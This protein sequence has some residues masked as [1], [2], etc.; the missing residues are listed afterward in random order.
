VAG[1][2]TVAQDNEEAQEAWN[3]VLFDRFV[4]FRHIMV[5]GLA[6][7]GEEALRRHPPRPGDRVL[8][9]GCGFGDTAQRLA[10][11][12]GPEGD[13][14]GTDVAPRFIETAIEDAREAGVGNVRFAVGDL[15]VT[16]FEETFDYTFSRFGT[17]FFA[18]PGAAMRN[19][20]RAL[21]PGGRLCLVVW[22]RKL[23]NPWMHRAEEVVKPFVP[24]PEEGTDEPRCGPGPFSMADADTV[25]DILQGAGFQDV[26]FERCDIP[27]L[28]GHDLEEAIAMNTA[29][30]PAAEAI[31]LAGAG[32]DAVRPQIES[33][34]RAALAEFAGPNGVVA[35]A[36]TWIVTARAG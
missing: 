32:A 6:P 20:R 22:R 13:V 34:L 2:L 18:S 4:Q 7:H 8:D 25:S 9:I 19:V 21:A 27:I 3:G 10:E 12:V 24:E 5:G 28:I 33:E 17:M 23:D 16:H 36:S 11:M 29:L 31:R 35:G 1:E 30:G 14:L 26:C 15:Q